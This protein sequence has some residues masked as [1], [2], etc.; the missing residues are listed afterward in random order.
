M[1]D[2]HKIAVISSGNG[3]QT[4]AAY[5]KH[6]GYSV[7]LYVRERERVLMFPT[8]RVFHLRGVVQGDPAIDCIS[9]DMAEVIRGAHLIMVTTPAQYH[10]VVA[11]EMAPYL[12]DGQIVVLNPGRTFGTYVMKKTLA[13]A[14]CNQEVIIAEA[15]T[16]VFACRCARVAEPFIHGIKKHVR[17]AAHNPADT[18]KVMEALSPHFAGIMVPAENTFVT[19]FSN[20]GM[21]F[22]PLPILLNITRVETQEKFHYYTQGITPLV[23]NIIERMD[24]ER[25][26]IAKAYGADIP[27]AFEWM[28][29][30]YGAQ[31]DTLYERIQNTEAYANIYAP[32]DIDTR[33]I[34]EDMLTGCV[35]IYYAGHA[36]GVDA[37]IINSAILWASTIY[38]TDF[39]QNGRNGEVIDFYSFPPVAARQ[40]GIEAK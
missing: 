17:V 36:I 15:E 24:R 39:K 3:G 14:G 5:L 38:A 25:I 10:P 19:S 9:C 26:E 13:E 16:F 31:G 32:T 21:I 22:H 11:R 12:E 6:A 7:S 28:G 1:L 34:Y 35:P 18:P 37:P 33:Y 4:M 30:H 40:P 2:L 29:E 23:A 27:S 20:I 8:D